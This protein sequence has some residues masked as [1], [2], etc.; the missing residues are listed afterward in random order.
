MRTLSIRLRLTLWYTAVLFI[1][2]ITV[3]FG[4]FLFMQNKLEAMAQ[5]E[6]ESGFGV[7]SDVLRISEGDIMDVFHLG[8]T[9]LFQIIRAGAVVY[10]TEAWKSA[11]WAKE[12]TGAV[13][14]ANRPLKTGD[15][16]TYLLKSGSV[17]EYGF[18]ITIAHD[19][20]A[21]IE[22]IHSLAW[23]LVTAIP[24]TL[25]LALAGGYFLAGRVLSPVKAVTRKA[26]EIR[27]DRL[28]E[29]LPVENPGDEIGQLAAA[30]NDT[31]SRLEE[32]FER[33]RRFTADASHELRTPL[34]S[35]RSVGEVALQDPSDSAS[36]REAIGSM[37][38]EIQ[39]ITRLV[40]SLLTLA[41]GDSGK[42]KLT[43]CPL[44]LS[45]LVGE[46]V[47]ELGVLAE[48]KS[49]MLS[50][51]LQPAL[52]PAVD[53]ITLR[54]A[55][56]NVLHNAIQNTP[57]DGRIEVRTGRVGNGQVAIDITDNGPGIPESERARV[58][59]RFYRLDK[60]RSRK[61]GGFGLGLAIAQWAVE[62]NGGT[63]GFHDKEGPGA[64]CRI[65]LPGE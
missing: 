40:D 33:L 28:S 55:I 53:R 50:T 59:E 32:S 64:W 56:S 12:L 20:A 1:I 60:A 44:D 6:L 22:S 13:P 43:P 21:T 35:M 49:Q 38:E 26:R 45:A 25:A 18:E 62:L 3:S 24:C 7:V 54:L 47:E 19:A 2:Q 48:E 63:I 29:R 5:S 39:S 11:P 51:D 61:E 16:H 9:R 57:G 4:V 14:G 37:L 36:C 30:F 41:R 17:P 58:F 15:G 65:V 23:I 42:A 27:A 46:V 34:T 31:L 10:Q 52:A 8:Q